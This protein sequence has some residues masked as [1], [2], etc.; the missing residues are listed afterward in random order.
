M[1]RIRDVQQTRASFDYQ[2]SNL[3]HG[4][5]SLANPAFRVKVP[6]LIC[7]LTEFERPVK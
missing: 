5:W 4:E 6:G 7:A 3:P 2:W 1:M